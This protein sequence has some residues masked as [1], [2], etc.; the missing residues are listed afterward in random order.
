MAHSKIRHKTQTK[1][2][3]KDMQQIASF[4][5]D[6]RYRDLPSWALGVYQKYIFS[7]SRIC[8]W[9]ILYM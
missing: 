6:M 8:T 2:I 4:K 5:I 7:K 9:H 1:L 3:E